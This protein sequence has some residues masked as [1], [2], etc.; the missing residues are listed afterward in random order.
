ML[1]SNG[2]TLLLTAWQ[3]AIFEIQALNGYEHKIQQ[4][5]VN[6]NP[7]GNAIDYQAL[8]KINGSFRCGGTLVTRD[9]V[10]TAAHCAENVNVNDYQIEFGV[11]DRSN[12]NEVGKISR[13]VTMQLMHPEYDEEDVT[14]DHDILLLYLDEAVTE[15][16]AIDLNKDG[17]LLQKGDLLTVSGWGNAEV[18]GDPADKLMS[19]DVEYIPNDECADMFSSLPTYVIEDW[20]L[21][22]F[23]H[24]SGA[25]QGDSGGPLVLPADENTVPLLVGLVLFGIECGDPTYPSI[26]MKMSYYNDWIKSNIC[27][28][29][30]GSYSFCADFDFPSQSPFFS[31]QPTVLCTDFTGYEDSVGDDCAWYEENDLE[32]RCSCK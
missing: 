31:L 14:N 20:H 17:S 8:I 6:G 32:G 1:I 12:Y 27:F 19:V 26:F 30:S 18:G 10:I 28:E 29:F 9:V 25:C 24:S 3:I 11:Y 5:I 23:T 13:D 4:R 7:V 2:L 22:A 15:Y 21:C 16:D